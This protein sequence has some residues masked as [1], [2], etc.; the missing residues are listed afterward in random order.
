MT[1]GPG[2]RTLI[3]AARDRPCAVIVCR[4]CCCGNPAVRPGTG[5]ERH[6]DRMRAAAVASGGRF[7]VRTTDC[8][9][10]CGHADVVVIR[11]SGAGRRGGGRATWIGW[12]MDD[13]CVDDIL[14]WAAAG[15]PGVAEPPPALELQFI[16]PAGSAPLG[17]RRRT[18]R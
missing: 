5:H 16:Q 12:A 2:P 3:G 14:R 7:T 10:P 8:L 9:G 4:G 17:A 1:A 18:R 6:L 15:G 13:A 11:P